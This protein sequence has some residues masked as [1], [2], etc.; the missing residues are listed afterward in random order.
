[1]DRGL[2]ANMVGETVQDLC[3]CELLTIDH[4]GTYKATLLGQAIVASSLSVEDGIFVHAEFQRA[5][6]SFVM[7][8]EMHVFYLFTPI[9]PLGLGGINWPAFRTE[10]DRLDDSGLR[11]LTLAG[12]KPFV[13]NRM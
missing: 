8:G 13:V 10:M 6:Q 7:D 9:Q 12:V 3:T 4:D 1:M 5:L 11:A 2:L